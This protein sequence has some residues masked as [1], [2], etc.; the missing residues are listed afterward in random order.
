MTDTID[1]PLTTQPSQPPS[2]PGKLGVLELGRWAWRQLTSMRT[3]LI[4]LLLLGLAS[5]PGSL[6]PQEPVD[7][8]AVRQ[9]QQMH[10]KLTPVYERL[11][12]FHVYGSPWFSAIYLLL[13]VSLVGC[14]L[15]RLRVYWRAATAPPPRAPRNLTRLPHSITGASS[16]SPQEV[17]SAA[18]KL[19]RRQGYRVE[20]TSSDDGSATVSAQRGYLRE[21]GNLVFHLSLVVILIAFAAGSF[22]GFRGSVNLVQGQTFTNARQSYDDFAPGPLFRADSLKPFSF[23]LDKFEANFMTSGPTLGQ[24]TA[25]R[26][27]LSYS[28]FP[29]ADKEKQRVEVN[30]P[31]TIGDT[32]VFLVGNGYAPA[33][34][35]HDGEGNTVY[36]GP[37]V[38]MPQDAG[39]TSVGVVKAPDAKPSQLGLDARLLPTYA[40]SKET[41][42]ISQ[43]PDAMNP[44]LSMAVYQGDLG[45]SNGVPQSVYALDKT[46]LTAV[47][48]KTGKPLTLNIP[49]GA[50][51]KLPDGL[52]SVTFDG[53]NRWT[54][55]QVSSTPGESI[56]LGGV[57]IGLLGLMGSLFIR[58]RRIWLRAH[59]T[60]VG[61]A[62]EIAGL[63]RLEGHGLDQSLTDFLANIEKA[64]T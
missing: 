27:D 18:R 7:P 10:P 20:T 43:F 62:L 36:S 44:V 1:A 64:T 2:A 35:V 11:D 50:T 60:E 6:V 22:F 39:Y 23:T 16:A 55:L 30:R 49:M 21:A 56:A 4:L 61:A 51:R 38:F 25:F 59:R 9:W 53:L 46:K 57:I 33:I 14:I 40:W 17:T 29:G 52:G 28:P 15:P 42:P 63:D 54:R 26:A 37:T 58:P 34:T 48:D 24:P 13:M 3:A 5:V 47:T 31:L 8:N 32:S 19:L 45:L 12:V 41:G